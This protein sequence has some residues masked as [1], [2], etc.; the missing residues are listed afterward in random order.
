MEKTNTI[1]QENKM[2]TMPVNK[3]LLSMA[4]PMMIAMIVQALYNIVDSVFVTRISENALTATSLAFPIQNLMIAVG[5]GTGV[6][7][8]ALLSKS[9]GEKNFK[10]ANKA[11][12]NGIFLG[13]LSFL[14]FLIFGI[15]GSRAFFLSQTDIPE[16]IDF[17]TDYIS[18]C[19]I[20]SFGVFGQLI[21]ERLLQSTGKT[22]YTMI[23]QGVGAIINIIL[24][25]ILIFGLFGFPRLEVAGAAIATV[26]GQTVAMLL[27]IYFNIHNNH[28]I[29]LSLKNFR[30]DGQIIKKIYAIG[31]PSIIM[32]AIGSVMVY[33]LNKILLS[34]TS[35][36]SAVFGAYFKLQSFVLMPV[37]GLN[38]GMI[39]ILAYN[40]GA[41]KKERIT[42][43]IKISV[44]FAT[45]I[46]FCG[47]MAMQIFPNNILMLFKASEDMLS[48]GIPALRT[49][50]ISFLFAGCSIILTS[51]FQALGHGVLSLEVSV[52]RQLVILLPV[53]YL[54]SLTGNVNAIWWSFPISEIA[55]LAFSLIFMKKVYNKQIKVIES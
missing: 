39:P 29:K 26:T 48:I 11:A 5:A 12:N 50:S 19:S 51:V 32:M 28:E 24:D 30:P 27:A 33:G 45:C 54:L 46:T 42:K 34:F 49:I 4:I 43:T 44:V 20:F 2:G 31:L 55:S 9:L 21:F 22:F 35:T 40:L 8:N 1:Q 23:T 37:F 3:L 17:G 6:G 7:I 41:R 13:I 53:A 16:I 52:I 47:F 25:P 18:I 14:A 38:N 36:A 15:F 10:N